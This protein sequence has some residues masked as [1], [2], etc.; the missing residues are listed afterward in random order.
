LQPEFGIEKRVHVDKMPLNST[1]FDE[2][3]D[4]LSLYWTSQDV[5]TYLAST[6]DDPH[7]VHIKSI[8]DRP[9]GSN[10]ASD[11]EGS[12]QRERSAQSG[13]VDHAGLRTSG[14]HKIQDVK[15]LM[16]V[17]VIVTSDMTKS[18]PVLVVYACE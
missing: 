2:H 14:G 4:V 1:V 16:K 11:G 13:K 8:A 18:P 17:H 7:L 15:E 12:A 3:K 9:Q 10:S 5:L 6:S